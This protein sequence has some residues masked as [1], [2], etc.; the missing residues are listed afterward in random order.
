[1]Y[2]Y[3]YVFIHTHIHTQRN[4]ILFIFVSYIIGKPIASVGE[5]M[6]TFIY[7][8]EHIKS[9][10]YKKTSMAFSKKNTKIFV[11]YDVATSL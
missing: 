4:N 6:T 7:S 1:M 2:L 8:F 3:V 10:S 11:A 9:Y 5:E